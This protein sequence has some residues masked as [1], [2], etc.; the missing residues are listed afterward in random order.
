MEMALQG[1][2]SV[3]VI[4]AYAPSSSA[5]DENVQQFDDDIERAMADSDS[6]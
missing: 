3:T 6:K 1:K 2:N 4:N 5:E